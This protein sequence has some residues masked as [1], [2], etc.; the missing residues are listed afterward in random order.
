[1][2]IVATALVAIMRRMPI[3]FFDLMKPANSGVVNFKPREWNSFPDSGSGRNQGKARAIQGQCFLW[4]V[5][6]PEG[7]FRQCIQNLQVW[8][9]RV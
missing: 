6:Q 1:M 9:R 4:Y 5:G 2:S 7:L 8:W 3:I